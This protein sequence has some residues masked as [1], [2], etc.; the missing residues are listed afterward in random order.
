MCIVEEAEKNGWP[1]AE[2]GREVCALHAVPSS[3]QDLPQPAKKR[4]RPKGVKNKVKVQDMQGESTPKK[5]GRPQK[6]TSSAD[7]PSTP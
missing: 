1:E 6:S 3:A 4:G 7:M 5:R 2:E